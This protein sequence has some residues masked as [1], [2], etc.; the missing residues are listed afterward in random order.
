MCTASNTAEK[1]RW[2]TCAD[3]LLLLRERSGE[4]FFHRHGDDADEVTCILH[5]SQVELVNVSAAIMQE[6]GLK[7]PLFGIFAQDPHDVSD[8]VLFGEVFVSLVALA[9]RVC[10]PAVRYLG[11]VGTTQL[12]VFQ[13]ACDRHFVTPSSE[14]DAIWGYPKD[15]GMTAAAQQSSAV[16]DAFVPRLCVDTTPTHCLFRPAVRRQPEPAAAL[17]SA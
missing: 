4:P 17:E 10:V 6:Y 15:Q 12:A 1:T 7:K 16:V 14:T 3:D 11:K 5:G 8:A 2:A 13:V 9:D